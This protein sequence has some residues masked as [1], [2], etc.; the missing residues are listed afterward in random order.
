MKKDPASDGSKACLRLCPCGKHGRLVGDDGFN[1][2][3]FTSKDEALHNLVTSQQ[4]GTIRPDLVDGIIVQIGTSS[5]PDM[6]DG[7][8]PEVFGTI[9]AY[10]LRRMAAGD[11]GETDPFDPDKIHE[12]LN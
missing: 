9:K 3:E 8:D 2:F 1:G 11:P 6:P 4:F 5:L 10:N 7:V 12:T